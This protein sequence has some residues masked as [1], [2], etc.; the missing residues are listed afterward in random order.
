MSFR[1]FAAGAG[2]LAA[3][4]F[5]TTSGASAETAGSTPSASKVQTRTAHARA[6][7]P[8][9]RATKNQRDATKARH[10]KRTRLA[11]AKHRRRGA[12]EP[13]PEAVRRATAPIR[14]EVS[15][16]SGQQTA[17]AR[18]FRDFLNPQSFSVAANEELRGP[19]LLAAH[20]S[21]AMADPEIAAL[22]NPATPAAE[23]EEAP[24][25]VALH[26][27]MGDDSRSPAPALAHSDGVQ[28]QRATQSGK[29][30]ERMSFLSWFFVAWGGVLTFASAVRM[31]VG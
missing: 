7:K 14:A 10:G 18:R 5:A 8:Q 2:M 20:F 22:A 1:T 25:V 26:Q 27:T 3:L 23:Q 9:H 6:A 19:R 13:T 15:L 4:T 16:A 28:V 31:A 29:Q 11:A 30:P 17:A 12:A 24:A 21:G